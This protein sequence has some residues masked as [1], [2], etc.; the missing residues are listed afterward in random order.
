M[1]WWI[2]LLLVLSLAAIVVFVYY[3]WSLARRLDRLHRRVLQG[4]L[5]VDRALV[6]RA[7]DA[8][9]LADSGLLPPEAAAELRGAAREALLSAELVDDG[10]ER[11]IDSRYACETHLTHVIGRIVPEFSGKLRSDP[12][13]S[14]L[15]EGL[16]ASGYRVHVTRSLVNQD[17]AQVRDFRA[18]PICRVFHLAGRATLPDFA[19]FDDES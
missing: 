17:V 14:Q 19:E 12:F 4:M 3:L 15:L 13:G 1:A 11:S 16:S 9:Q 5:R 7:S 6:R 18:R 10:T 2:W 8:L